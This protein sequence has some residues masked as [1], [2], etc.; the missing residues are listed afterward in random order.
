MFLDLR[1]IDLAMRQ[2]QKEVQELRKAAQ[3]IR[4]MTSPDRNQAEKWDA[5]RDILERTRKLEQP[6]DSG[7][8]GLLVES[9]GEKKLWHNLNEVIRSRAN[10][11]LMTYDDHVCDQLDRSI[12]KLEEIFNQEVYEASESSAAE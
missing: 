1:T 4:E 10:L 2:F 12:A 5:V 9:Q 3:D 6:D 8:I 7:A 11:A